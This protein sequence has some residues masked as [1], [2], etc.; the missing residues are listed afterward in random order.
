MLEPWQN[1]AVLLNDTS[2]ASLL[3]VHY[4]DLAIKKLLAQ[5]PLDSFIVVRYFES[6]LNFRSAE[7]HWCSP[8]YMLVYRDNKGV[9]HVCEASPAVIKAWAKI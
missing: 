4:V 9:E 1:G 2:V 8:N 7:L 6:K 5:P 3:A